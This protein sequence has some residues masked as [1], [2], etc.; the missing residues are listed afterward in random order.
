MYRI[1]KNIS[2]LFTSLA[3]EVYLMGVGRGGDIDIWHQ[4]GWWLLLWVQQR[5][6]KFTNCPPLS[7]A[8]IIAT[9][10]LARHLCLIFSQ[11]IALHI[12]DCHPRTCILMNI[13][14]T[15][16]HQYTWHTYVRHVWS[17]FFDKLTACIH[18]D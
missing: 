5:P 16:W 9:Y 7:A 2:Y 6:N 4:V 3:W 13:K 12:Y 10:R 17:V 14:C 18:V 15:A 1:L 11:R 8:D